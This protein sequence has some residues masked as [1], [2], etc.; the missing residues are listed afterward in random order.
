MCSTVQSV[1]VADGVHATLKAS[2]GLA[3]QAKSTGGTADRRT[4]EGSSL[5]DDILRCVGNLGQEAAHNAA[6]TGS[7]LRIANRNHSRGQLTLLAVEGNK[8]FA[9]FS[10]AHD[11]RMA[12]NLI[13]IISMHRLAQLQHNIV[14]YVDYVADG[15]HAAG[16][17]TTLHPFGRRSNFDILQHAGSKTAAQL[18]RS[19]L[20]VHIIACLAL[21]SLLN[22]HSRHF[23]RTAGDSA[24]FTSQTDNAEAVSTVA[25][26]VD[27]NNG[28]IQTK[29]RLHI[30]ANRRIRRQNE[31]A[32]A[33]LGQQQL[34]VNAQLI[35][36]AQH[37]E[38]IQAAHF[39]LFQLH[40]FGIAAAR[41]QHA[42]N[43]GNRHNV[44]LVYILR[45]GQ[46]LYRLAALA[47]IHHANPQMVAVRMTA[48]FHNL[49]G[50]NALQAFAQFLYRVNLQAHTGNFI[51]QLLSGDVNIYI[52]F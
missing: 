47:I 38:G 30:N 25:G 41:R 34:G 3:A 44:I 33:L 16:T 23:Q 28:V 27:I 15:A 17:Q 5:E 6:Q 26:Q 31:D 21:S 35:G 20:Y 10:T 11:E 45:T 29:H 36:A 19:N 40:A 12:G 50:N 13:S 22:V 18:R 9:L 49:T 4:V 1:V 32:L 39:S 43:Y 46:N 24:D 37:A 14:R 7:L 51:A 52:L 42:A 48:D 2:A 8:L